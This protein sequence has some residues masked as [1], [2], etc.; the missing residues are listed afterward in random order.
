VTINGTGEQTRDFVYVGDCALANLLVMHNG[1]GQIYNLGSGMGTSVNQIFAC[2]RDIAAY[3][4]EPIHGPPKTGE[5]FQIYLDASKARQELDW[6]PTIDLE[7][8]LRRTVTYFA[9]EDSGVIFGAT[10]Q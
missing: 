8:G 9:G 5:T 10:E 1:P 6:R 4:Q 3:E 7:E 2:L